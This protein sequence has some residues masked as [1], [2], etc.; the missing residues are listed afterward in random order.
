M[1]IRAHLVISGRVQGVGFRWFVYNIASSLR[2]VGWA[3]NL[4]DG[5]VEAIFEGEKETVEAAIRQCYEGPRSAIVSC[6]D[7]DWDETPEGFTSFDIR[8]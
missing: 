3:K 6:I 1:N 7:T 2:L 8:Y 4:A 5:R